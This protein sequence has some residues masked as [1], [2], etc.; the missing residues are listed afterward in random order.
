MAAVFKAHSSVVVQVEVIEDPSVV[1]V[2]LV[3]FTPHHRLDVPRKEEAPYPF[4]LGTSLFMNL[5]YG[6]RV[7]Q[8]I[9]PLS[10]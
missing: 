5:N 3:L 8:S 9:V 6:C 1:G 7:A 2:I 4:T 10:D